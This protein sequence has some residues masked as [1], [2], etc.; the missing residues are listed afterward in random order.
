MTRINIFIGMSA[1]NQSSAGSNNIFMGVSAGAF[2]TGSNNILIGNSA[3][4][5]GSYSNRLYI[6]NSSTAALIYGEFDNRVVIFNGRVGVQRNPGTNALEVNGTASKTTAGSW[7]ANSD[8]RIKTQIQDIENAGE[9]IMRLHP[10]KF[11]YTDE[12][13]TKNPSIQNKFYYNFIAQEF[14]QV[15]PESVQ[16]SGEFI[17]GQTEE[18]LQMD[19]YNAQIVAIKALQEVIQQN[20]DQQKQI[21]IQQ[22][23]IDE[24]KT[25]IKSLTANKTIRENNQPVK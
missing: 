12:W 19:S 21:G 10:V 4:Y 18:L 6:E 17:E 20:K 7:L 3:G 22:K 13:K 5:S 23:E 15:F 1:G 8:Y 16:G 9:L 14:Q 2:N 25:I 11:R 24:L